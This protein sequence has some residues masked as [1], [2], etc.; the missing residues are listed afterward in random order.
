MTFESVVPRLLEAAEA[1]PILSAASRVAV[2][3]DLKGRV[4]LA[5]EPGPA[6]TDETAR[7]QLSDALADRLGGWWAPPV[8][9]TSGPAMP[10][11]ERR[12]ARA[13][14]DHAAG[15]NPR[16]PRDWPT[17]VVDVLGQR[18][19]IEPARWVGFER[20]L[21]KE[22]WLSDQVVRPVWPLVR[23]A[24]T[25]VSFYSY[26]GGVG[27]STLLALTAAQLADRGKQ[28]VVVDLDLEAPGL[29]G[30]F[31]VQVER[32]VLDY[33]VEHVALDRGDTDGL[34]RDVVTPR[35]SGPGNGSVRVIPAGRV[36]WSF[37]GKLARLD[38][39]GH[40]ALDPS[41]SPIEA[42]L[43]ALLREIRQSTPTPDFILLDARTGLHDLGGLAIHA[44]A[45]VD[46]LVGRAS[47]ADHE[48]LTLA[49]RAL[50]RRKDPDD[51]NLVLVQ[52]MAAADADTRRDRLEDARERFHEVFK[53]SVW[54]TLDDA[55]LPAVADTPAPHAP[56]AV[57]LDTGVS[58]ARSLGEIDTTWIFGHWI[59]PIVDRIVEVAEATQ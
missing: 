46:V 53:A 13:L 19:P 31:D 37:V 9:F 28:V 45:H 14:I 39:A 55:D 5:V 17:E 40:G 20:T 25:I 15:R 36:D 22:H 23:Q 42:G 27:R 12:V 10:R 47:P 41:E 50:A 8:L 30:L 38:F 59:T 4:R 3:R 43:K 54:E 26:K 18:R 6:P 49:L 11:G 56:F 35:G 21:S 33:L 48:G 29:Q 16:W 57:P 32:G 2:V 52:S 7:Q 24:P 58:L 51:I 1:D 44:L 34:A